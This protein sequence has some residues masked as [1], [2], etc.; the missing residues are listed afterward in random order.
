L[1]LLADGSVLN[2]FVIDMS[3]SGAAVSAEVTPPIGTPLAVGRI[4]GKV[5]RHFSEGFAIKFV[6][7]QS[8]G[9]L[10]PLLIKR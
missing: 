7:Q 10:E 9:A 6:E 2:C 3:I 4:V 5:V 1:V 8:A